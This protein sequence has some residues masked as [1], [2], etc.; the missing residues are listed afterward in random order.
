[1]DLILEKHG[2]IIPVEIKS[3]QEPHGLGGLKSFLKDHTV[4]NAYCVCKT[5]RPYKINDIIFIPW[6]DFIERLYTRSLFN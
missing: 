2:S 1:V 4:C 6:Q 3:S 5:P